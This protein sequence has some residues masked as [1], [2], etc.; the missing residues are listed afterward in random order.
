MVVRG[1]GGGGL[2]VV[3]LRGTGRGQ[4]IAMVLSC[5]PPLFYLTGS[6][7]TCAQRDH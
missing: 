2:S 5:Y 6:I 7:C 1:E 3:K 4:E